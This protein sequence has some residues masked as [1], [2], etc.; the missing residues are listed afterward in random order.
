L[1]SSGG[2]PQRRNTLAQRRL[3]MTALSRAALV[4]ALSALPVA[5][6]AA[7]K[8]DVSGTWLVEVEIN[9][10]QGTPEFTFKQDG[11]KLTGKYK[12]QFGNADVKGTLKGNEIEFSF[13]V[14]G[15]AKITYTGTVE[16]D[17]TMKGKANYADQAMGT[18]TAKKKPAD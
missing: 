5:A 14:Q 15:E 2:L 12:G 4:L 8:V 6:R 18:W 9:G 11:E 7:D 10:M 17:G 16:K 1:Y 13:D 3:A